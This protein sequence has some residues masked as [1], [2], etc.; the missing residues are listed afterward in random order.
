[1]SDYQEYRKREYVK[2]LKLTES[3]YVFTTNG[4]EFGREGDYLMQTEDG[5]YLVSGEWFDEQYEPV[6]EEVTEA[7]KFVP[8]GKTV[9][10]VIEF[11]RENPEEIER[12]KQLERDGGSRKGILEYAV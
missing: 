11:L 7:R 9:E 1:M 4:K 2:A 8:A 6:P 3:D 5:T 10:Q 12:V